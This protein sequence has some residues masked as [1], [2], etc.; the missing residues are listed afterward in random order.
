MKVIRLIILIPAIIAA[1]VLT[2]IITALVFGIID[3]FNAEPSPLSFIWD[4]FLKSAIITFAASFSAMYIY[5][6]E[7]K[8]PSLILV[9]ILYFAM[10]LLLSYNLFSF[11]EYLEGFDVSRKTIISL[12]ANIIGNIVALVIMWKQNYD[13]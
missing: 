9:T 12:V 2:N 10:Y 8:Y 11:S 6:Y 3:Y 13:Y 5:P 7:K 1:M 4:S